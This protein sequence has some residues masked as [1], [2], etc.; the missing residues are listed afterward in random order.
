MSS[1]GDD[2]ERG[3]ASSQKLFIITVCDYKQL[4]DSRTK[5]QAWPETTSYNVST[6][7]DVGNEINHAARAN[8]KFNT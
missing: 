4:F 1:T 2:Q 6:S 3:L 5:K 8:L 7:K